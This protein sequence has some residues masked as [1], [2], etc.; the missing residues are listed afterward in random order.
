M[1][2]RTSSTRLNRFTTIDAEDAEKLKA[3]FYT[4]FQAAL[5]DAVASVNLN[6]SDCITCVD[7]NESIR[8]TEQTP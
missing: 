5:A 8:W 1:I 2:E 6:D 3:E 7:S 4:E